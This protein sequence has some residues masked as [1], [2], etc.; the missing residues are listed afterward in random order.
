MNPNQQNT[1][2]QSQPNPTEQSTPNQPAPTPVFQTVTPEQPTNPIAP[3]PPVMNSAPQFQQPIQPQT[4][5]SPIKKWLI[6]ISSIIGLVII[7]TIFRYIGNQVGSNLATS[8]S[9]NA[10]YIKKVVATAKS[11]STLPMKVDSLTTLQDI[12]ATDKAV[13]YTYLLVDV[14]PSKLSS[15]ALRTSILNNVCKNADTKAILDRGI[16]LD[17]DYKVQDYTET[18]YIS[19]SEADC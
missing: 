18:Y 14:D 12:K 4:K 3:A 1:D 9:S 19:I 10:D 8:T 5:K 16:L 17:Y 11:S 6:T 7:G 2:E 15:S 13:V